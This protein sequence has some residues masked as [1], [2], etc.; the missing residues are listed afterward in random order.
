M[1]VTFKDYYALLGVPRAASAEEIKKAY[2]RKAR[3]LHPDRNKTK[4]AEE[5]FREVNEAYEVLGDPQKRVRYDQLGANWREGETFQPP[6]GFEGFR[7]DARDLGDLS[8]LFGRTGRTGSAGGASG[9]SDFFDALFGDLG[10][11]GVFGG[12]EATRRRGR[13]ARRGG[14]VEAEVEFSIADLLQPG[15][16]TFTLGSPGRDGALSSRTVT[17]NIPPGLR[18]GQ[19]LRLPGQ[20]APGGAGHAAG[21][22]YLKVRVRP[23]AGVAIHG[24]DIVTDIDV[25]APIAVVGGEVRVTAPDG[26][27]TIRVRP[28]TP[29]GT[30]LRVRGRGLPRRDGQRGDLLARVRIVIPEH[31]TQEERGLYERLAQLHKP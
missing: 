2:R 23:E 17:V 29:T 4:G 16:K 1:P 26:V 24:D 25:P 19:K 7:F 31:P 8:E 12:S 18:D 22:I 30:T 3:E 15:R 28:A 21:D 10:M 6:P 13:G 20:G 27:V 14:D 5:R 9:F 11:G